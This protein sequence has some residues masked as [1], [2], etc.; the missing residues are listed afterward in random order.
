MIAPW[1]QD[2]TAGAD[3]GDTRLNHRLAEVLSTTG[4]HPNLSIPAASRLIAASATSR[5]SGCN[6]RTVPLIRHVSGMML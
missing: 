3:L 6:V 4:T 2:E 5:A 1:A